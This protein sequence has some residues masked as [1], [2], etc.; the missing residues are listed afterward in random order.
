MPPLTPVVKTLLFMNVGLYLLG[1]MLLGPRTLDAL[2]GLWPL[3]AQGTLLAHPAY[4][5]PHFWPWQLVTYGFLH[6]GF[7]HLFFNMFALWMFGAALER[8][9]G[10]SH[11]LV[12]YFFCLIG[13]GVVQLFV[14]TGALAQGGPPVPTIGASG[15]VF[16]LL[17]AFGMMFPNVKLIL[18]FFPVPIAA[19]YFVVLYGIIELWLG[20]TNTMSTVAHF[21]HLGGMIFGFVLIQYWRGKLPWKPRYILRM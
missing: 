14:T 10:R 1:T 9:W 21:A 8:L 4:N 19:K 15:A 5:G 7:A 17:L 13:A 16:G 12:Y 20:V 11:F 3:A 18:L 2:F 6:G